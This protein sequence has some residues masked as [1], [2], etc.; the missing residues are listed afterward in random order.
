MFSS[1]VLSV[2]TATESIASETV[3]TA[4]EAA[5]PTR[6]TLEVFDVAK[7]SKDYELAQA[8][9]QKQGVAGCGG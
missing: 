3:V 1:A 8:T 5:S 2:A 9:A 4:A 7:I 6:A